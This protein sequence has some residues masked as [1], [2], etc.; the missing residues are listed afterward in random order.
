M[1][2]PENGI[3]HAK[4]FSDKLRPRCCFQDSKRQ[5]Q[6]SAAC[7]RGVLSSLVTWSAAKV[8]PLPQKISSVCDCSTPKQVLALLG[9]CSFYCRSTRKFANVAKPLYK[10]NGTGKQFMWT[11]ACFDFPFHVQLQKIVYS[12]MWYDYNYCKVI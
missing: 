2:Y 7:S 5:N 9:L 8:S 1:I 4:S 10:L 3:I 12:L 11:E 6:K